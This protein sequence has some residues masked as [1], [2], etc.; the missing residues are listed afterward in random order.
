MQSVPTRRSD[1]E[2]A[3]RVREVREY[4]FSRKLREIADMRAAGRD[5]VSLG[6]GG[7]DRP[8]QPSVVET[9]CRESRRGDVHSYQP[10]AGIAELREEF[11]RWYVRRF[12]VEL[13]PSREVLPLIGSK[14]GILHVSLAFLNPGD[15]VL[16][17]DPGYPAYTSVSRL[18]GARIYSYGLDARNGWMPDFE[19]LERMPLDR[20]KLMWVN[21]PNMPTGARA[22]RGTF[23]R[24]IDFARRH[25][26]VVVNDNPYC[27]ILN[28]NPLSILSA[29]GARDVAIEL[30]S[31][32]KSHNMAGWRVGM[33]ASC[34]RFTEWILRVKSNVDSGMFRPL[35][36]AAAEALRAGD[37]WYAEQN[38]V[39]ARRRAAAERI[40]LAAG[41]TFDSSQTGLF[42]WGRV[43][44][45][46]TGGELADRLLYDAGVFVTPGA[47]FGSRGEEYI[48][49]SL[50]A[51]EERMAE[52]LARIEKMM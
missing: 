3:D 30:N 37:G 17:P 14:E 48:R 51:S 45:G 26:I 16:V 32:S 10:Y 44:A 33:L 35:Q 20:V 50:C 11:A 21:Y 42:L 7:P 27:F 22:T 9:L 52:A 39:Y 4:F 23:E 34:S 18:V 47:V 29:D 31:L 1:F 5:V 40:M 49:I 36:S 28:D 43:P 41:C 13:D 25:R 12:G 46:M 38:R 15:G 19:E 6:I 24:L 8:P 2:P